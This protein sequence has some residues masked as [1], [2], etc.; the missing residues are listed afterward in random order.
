MIFYLLDRDE[1][2]EEEKKKKKR[3]KRIRSG[4]RATPFIYEQLMAIALERRAFVLSVYPSPIPPYAGRPGCLY[5]RR[6]A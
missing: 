3:E 4:E 6:R 1:E 2:E 5:I